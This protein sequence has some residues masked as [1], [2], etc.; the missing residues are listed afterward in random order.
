MTRSSK[1]ILEDLERSKIRL[2][3]IATT[4]PDIEPVGKWLARLMRKNRTPPKV[5]STE[6][7]WK[8]ISK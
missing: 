5:R 6:D 1:E 3:E 2:E 8:D 4:G 7:E